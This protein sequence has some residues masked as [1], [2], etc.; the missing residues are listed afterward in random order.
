MKVKRMRRAVSVLL[1]GILPAAGWAASKGPDGFGYTGTDATVYSFVDISSGG[2]ASVLNGTDDGLAALTL[3]F[4]FAFYGQSYNTVCVSTNGALYF[5][6][7]SAACSGFNDFANTDI[8][9]AAP[10]N[11]LPAAL[12]FWTDLTFQVPGAGAVYYQTIGTAGSRQ[13]IVQWNNAYPQGSATPVTFEVILKETANSVIFQYQTVD[14]G[15]GNPASNGAQATVG[16]W[17]SAAAASLQIE[18]SYDVNV[19]SNSYAL[20]FST[21]QALCSYSTTPSGGVSVSASGGATSFVVNTQSGCPWTVTTSSVPSWI[22]IAS[23][24]SGTGNGAVNY[25]VAANGGSAR[26]ATLSVGG[27]TPAMLSISQAAPNSGGGGGG[28]GGGGAPTAPSITWNNPVSIPYGTALGSTQLNAAA[29]TPGNFVYSPAAGTVLGVGTQTLTVAF[30]PYSSSFTTAS[31]TV[32]IVVSKAP[33]TIKFGTIPNHLTSDAPFTLSAT[34]SSGLPVAFSIVS[35]PATIA[36]NTLTITGT[37]TV[38]VQAAQ[39]GNGNYAAAT[40][41][42]QSFTVGQAVPQTAGIMNAASAGQATAQVVTP[43]SFVA[44]YGTNM[45]GSGSP[46]ATTLPLP[47]TLNGTQ[48]TLG[49]IAMPLLYAAPGQVNALVPQ[50]L[51]PNAS[52]QLV[53]TVGSTVSA[54]V[55]LMVT[56]LQPGIYTVDQTGSGVGVVTHALTGQLV[57]AANPAHA[58]EYLTIYCTGLGSLLGPNGETEPADGTAAPLSPIFQTTA[59]VT[60]TIGGTD[61]TVTFAGLTPTLAAL[62]QVNVLM[63]AG[64]PTGSA[65][66]VIITTADAQT[67]VSVQSNAVTIAV[68]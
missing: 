48:V 5:V 44:I 47:T 6:P 59:T 23:G 3:P 68:Q 58:G 12:P 66:P 17:G 35:G 4:A 45:A 67:G 11:S 18:W 63:P 27:Q 2:A 10:P 29:N 30:Y 37:G 26:S 21:P 14:L 55:P 54:P 40:G 65:V 62:Y 7:N 41:V 24:S 9:T 32:T 43:G 51:A 31:A 20:L 46:S 1:L 38:T 34:A 19:L 22:T 8:T 28:G 13:F 15:P 42:T 16:I 64:V 53:V 50:S 25:T 49:G 39:A 36:S 57:N 52:Y 56:E 61:A 60:A 33:Q